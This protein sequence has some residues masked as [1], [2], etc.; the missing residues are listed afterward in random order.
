MADVKAAPVRW[1]WP[2]R[3]PL[4]KLVIVDGDPGLGKSTMLLDIAARVSSGRPMPFESVGGAA[5]D[6]VLISCEDGLADTVHPRLMHA[7][8]DTKRVHHCE[9]VEAGDKSRQLAL[10]RDVDELTKLVKQTE[11]A[12]V[13]IDPFV[14]FLDPGVDSYRDQDIRMALAPLTRMA[15]ETSATIVLVRHLNKRT[16]ASALHR[17]GGSVG[18][19]GAARAGILVARDPDDANRRIA[20]ATKSNLASKARSASFQLVDTGRGAAIVEWLSE[21]DHDADTLLARS[22]RAGDENGQLFKA[23]EFLRSELAGGPRPATDMENLARSEGIAKRT[24]SRAR[25]TLDVRS[26]KAGFNGSA[27]WEW[28]LPPEECHDDALASFT[29]G[30]PHES[31]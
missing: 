6:V 31:T 24:L 25:Q 3:F 15:E 28:S 2:G 8:A 23:Q 1:L 26:M 20:V 12:L 4:G 5:R 16:D 10:P 9:D 14:A 17:G 30:E 7:G 19:I 18:I 11:A 21:G 13:I 27:H 22:A 29:A